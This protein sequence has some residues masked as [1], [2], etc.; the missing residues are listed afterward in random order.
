MTK[1]IVKKSRAE[2]KAGEIDRIRKKYN[3]LAFCL[4]E[5][6]RRLWS[7]SEALAYG[8]GGIRLVSNATGLSNKTIQQGLKEL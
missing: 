3:A 1:K 7:A 8:Y 4:N 6:G 2:I 5:H